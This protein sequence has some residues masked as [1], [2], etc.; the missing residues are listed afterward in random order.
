MW[1]SSSI[2]RVSFDQVGAKARGRGSEV[3]NT[4]TLVSI[5]VPSHR[6]PE[7]VRDIK[8]AVSWIL[9][10]SLTSWV[11]CL[12][13]IIV[14]YLFPCH[15][16]LP[17]H[18]RRQVEVIRWLASVRG[19][20]SAATDGIIIGTGKP[21]SYFVVLESSGVLLKLLWRKVAPRVTWSRNIKSHLSLLLA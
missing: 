20:P 9:M 7:H 14:L 6:T 10:G 2:P 11:P 16:S 15:R 12:D 19:V 8:P 17:F 5:S 4:P 13:Q 3:R 21:R 1:R 18:R